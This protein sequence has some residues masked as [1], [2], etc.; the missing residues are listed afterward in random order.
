MTWTDQRHALAQ[1]RPFD[2]FEM[3]LDRSH[4]HLC[5]ARQHPQ[6][7]LRLELSA[8]TARGRSHRGFGSHQP[9]YSIELE[10]D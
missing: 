1:S 7:A 6:A 8:R 3:H 10:P 4:A 5:A 2:G 9:V